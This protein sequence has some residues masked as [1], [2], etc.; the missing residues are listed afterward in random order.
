M[1]FII[2]RVTQDSAGGPTLDMTPDGEFRAPPEPTFSQKVLRVAIV[3]AVLAA[4]LAVA[5]L[6]L[7]LGLILI[8]VALGAALVAYLAFRWRVW[9]ARKSGGYDLYRR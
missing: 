5:A 9:Q 8:P 2:H 7:W 3:V 6:A 4:G 1:R